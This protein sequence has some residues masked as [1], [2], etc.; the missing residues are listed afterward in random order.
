M[1]KKEVA[2][3]LNLSTRAV[4]R[5]VERGRLSVQYRK[6]R[7]GNAAVFDP[8]EVK[9]FKAEIALPLPRPAKTE[10]MARSGDSPQTSS[11]TVGAA[12]I[13]NDTT[14]R[15]D[16]VPLTDK[17]TLSL[18]EASGLSG[19]SVDFL[20]KAIKREALMAFEA[21]GGYRVKRADLDCFIRD[22]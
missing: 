21:D 10:H 11:L 7:H 6:D 5:A 8:V 20:A 3:Y 19:L 13:F 14:V 4:E 2:E 22:L 9:R 18:D 1:R 15:G 16:Q 17:L 12:S